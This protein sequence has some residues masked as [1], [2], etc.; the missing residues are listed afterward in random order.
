MIRSALL[1]ASCVIACSVLAQ[2]HKNSPPGFPV[3][4][5]GK[6]L[7]QHDFMCTGASHDGRIV[8]GDHCHMVWTYDDNAGQGEISDAVML[9]NGNILFPHQ[10]GVREVT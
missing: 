9:S 1:F 8:I 7:S 4:D 2:T 5:P 3:P 6:G 10:F